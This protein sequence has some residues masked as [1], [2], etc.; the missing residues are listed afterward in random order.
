MADERP[1]DRP[2]DS[3]TPGA[4]IS[5]RRVLATGAATVL[6]GLGGAGSVAAVRDDTEESGKPSS[7]RPGKRPQIA[8]LVTEY[9]K[10]SHGQNIVD[11]FLGGYGW[12]S[13]WHHP[14]MDVVALYVDQF[15]ESDLSHERVARYPQLK[16]YPTIAEALT[17]GGD[18]LAVDGVLLIA[19][20]GRYP[21]NEKGQTLW[22]RYEFFMQMVD[23]FRA[24][25]R[26]VPVFFDKH[27]SWK[28]DQAVEMVELSRELGFPMLAGSSLP[29]CWRIPSLDLRWGAEVEE[30]FS[31]GGGDSDSYDIHSLEAMQCLVER[32]R[33]GE[34]GVVWIE[35]LRG[36]RV[37]KAFDSGSWQAGGW[38][39]RLFE[40]CLCRSLSLQQADE[41]RRHAYPTRE[42]LRK[43]VQGDPVA[44]RFEYADGLRATMLLLEPLTHDQTAAVRL[45]NESDPFSVLFYAGAGHNMQPNFFNPQV[46]HTESMIASGRP[47]YP[48]ERTLLT[49]GL[50][51]AGVESLWQGQKRLETPHLAIRY[52]VGEQ[53]TFRRT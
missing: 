39:P 27:L 52:Q 53:S 21:K 32:R 49:T 13:R 29:V 14:E 36:D 38:D 23:V 43:L 46:Y 4:R 41:T 33:G 51:A 16:L 34:T 18:K 48:V 2:V 3:A 42:D 11:R 35:A 37:W 26:S 45:K 24:S 1:S 15:P 20:H 9:R 7:K 30:I 19:E 47:P 8:A 12:E 10:Y 44:Y 28:W 40:A 25:G 31:V 6:A 50:T 17:Q 5:R 22:P